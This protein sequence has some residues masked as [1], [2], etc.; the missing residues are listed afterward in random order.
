MSKYC[1]KC[2]NTGKLLDGSPCTCRLSVYDMC[3]PVTSCT[4]I[5]QLY[6]NILFNKELIPSGLH[7][8]YGVFLDELI[9]EITSLKQKSLNIFI[10][11]PIKHSKTI[12]V[13]TVIEQLFRSNVAVFPYLDILEIHK[14]IYDIDMNRSNQFLIDNEIDP[15]SLYTV[16]YLFVKITDEL[17]YTVFD[18]MSILIDRRTRRGLTTVFLCNNSWEYITTAD[19]KGYISALKGDGSFGTILTKSFNKIRED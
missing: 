16:P 4:F 11:A 15:E 7:S 3:N 9:Q 6:R 10:G 19:K 1:T 18:T 5:P 13:Y 14:L 17:N 8:S 12:F 2:G